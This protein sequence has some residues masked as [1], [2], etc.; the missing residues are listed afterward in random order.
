VIAA[1]EGDY[2]AEGYVYQRYHPLAG[3]GDRRAV[4]GSWIIDG[5]PAGIGIREDGLVTG[6]GARFVPH[7]IE[8]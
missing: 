3:E 6:N 5:A 2:G 7:I 1:T 4:V 8:G